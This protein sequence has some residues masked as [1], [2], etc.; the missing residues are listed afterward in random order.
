MTTQALTLPPVTPEFQRIVRALG[1]EL[2]WKRVARMIAY[3]PTTQQRRTERAEAV[4]L[5]REAE[6]YLAF[7]NPVL[8]WCGYRKVS[9]FR[10]PSQQYGA[11]AERPR[12][13]QVEQVTVTERLADIL[14]NRGIKVNHERRTG[15]WWADVEDEVWGADDWMTE[16]FGPRYGEH[17]YTFDNALNLLRLADMARRDL[18]GR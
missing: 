6:A 9:R 13:T 2:G 5:K 15:K 11:L 10:K 1:C 14:A 8:N 16:C 4:N 3:G 17:P 12:P 18:K 7:E